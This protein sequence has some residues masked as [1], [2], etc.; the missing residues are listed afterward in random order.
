METLQK[1]LQDWKGKP[2]YVK[3]YISEEIYDE[4]EKSLPNDLLYRFDG[5]PNYDGLIEMV[6]YVC[7]AWEERESEW[8]AEAQFPFAF[9]FSIFNEW[10][11]EKDRVLEERYDPNKKNNFEYRPFFIEFKGYCT[12]R[13]YFEKMAKFI[14]EE[15]N[16]Y[17]SAYFVPDGVQDD[18][19]FNENGASATAI[20]TG[21]VLT[22]ASPIEYISG[23]LVIVD[24]NPKLPHDYVKL[25][26]DDIYQCQSDAYTYAKKDELQIVLDKVFGGEIPQTVKVYNVGQ[27][28]CAS[29]TMQSD[30][31]VFSDIGL[32]KDSQE[33][34]LQ[35]VRNAKSEIRKTA[36][37]LAVV[38]SH[39]DLDHILGVTN[40]ADNIYDAVWIVP[41][42]YTFK[43]NTR[44]YPKYIS[45]S[46]KRL[47][48]YL[49]WRNSTKLI[50]ISDEFKRQM[51]YQNSQKAF[52]IWTGERRLIRGKNR[53]NECYTITEANNFG[54]ILFLSNQ[55]TALL[56]GDCA[57]KVLPAPL[58]SKEINYLVAPHHCSKM[59]SPNIKPATKGKKKAVLTF[60]LYNTF[61]HPNPLHKDELTKLG[62]EILPTPPVTKRILNLIANP[63]KK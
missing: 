15:E 29:I 59:S 27:G 36:P 37:P 35:G 32:S 41:D 31:T 43:K 52:S 22:S 40:A 58:K 55:Y 44:T 16:V 9:H 10:V 61:G 20:L 2:I 12:N 26:N 50:R 8:T 54:L 53:R 17:F 48:K 38:L 47:L 63:T 18:S 1:S 33:L 56:P 7:R 6:N 4:L 57:Y 46:A 14:F 5:I 21:T 34:R 51:V 3:S 60:G 30:K 24:K 28:Y 23:R 62:Y 49:D 19:F 11:A 25:I 39:W 42:I 13:Q 45:T